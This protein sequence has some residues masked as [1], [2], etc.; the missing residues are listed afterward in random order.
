LA[1]KVNFERERERERERLDLIAK[2]VDNI[3]HY[4]TKLKDNDV[5]KIFYVN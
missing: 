3:T 5:S 4:T 1:S 2:L